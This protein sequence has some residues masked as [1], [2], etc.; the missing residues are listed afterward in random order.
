MFVQ[1]SAVVLLVIVVTLYPSDATYDFTKCADQPCPG[2]STNAPICAVHPDP[3]CNVSAVTKD[4][5]GANFKVED[6]F[7]VNNTGNTSVPDLPATYCYFVGIL[8]NNNNETEYECALYTT[9]SKE[10]GT[11]TLRCS[12]EKHAHSNHP[13][14]TKKP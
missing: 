10:N 5:F 2:V 3:V 11:T 13:E 14:S 1:F 7:C 9:S 4:N 8:V 12:I 6:A